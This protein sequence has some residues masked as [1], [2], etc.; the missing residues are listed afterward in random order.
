MA[1]RLAATA[2]VGWLTW[3]ALRAVQQLQADVV[4]A[5]LRI[6]ALEDHVGVGAAA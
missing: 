4:E 1:V 2:A 3:G 5:R 6:L